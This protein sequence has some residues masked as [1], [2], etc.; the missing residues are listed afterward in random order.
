MAE[1][2]FGEAGLDGDE[3]AVV[4]VAPGEM[5]TAGDVVELV[6]EVAPADVG[7]VEVESDVQQDG[8]DA[9]EGGELEGCAQWGA[10]GP[11]YGGRHSGTIRYAG[12]QG[13]GIFAS[14]FSET[15]VPIR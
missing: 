2:Q 14:E 4:D 9:E 13:S 12:V 10:G 11:D 1:E 8:E 5:A 3:G 7:L 15:R 6:A